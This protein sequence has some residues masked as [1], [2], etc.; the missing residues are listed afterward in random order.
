MPE[1]SGHGES[2]AMCETDEE[3]QFQLFM[4]Q[5]YMA[6]ASGQDLLGRIQ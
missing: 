5:I 2:R 1:I 3:T 6:G 4:E